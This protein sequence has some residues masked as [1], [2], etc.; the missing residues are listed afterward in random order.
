MCYIRH[1]V[2]NKQIGDQSEKAQSHFRLRGADRR[3]LE[4]RWHGHPGRETVPDQRPCGILDHHVPGV[5]V[6]P[7]GLR[8][9]R[10]Q[11]PGQVASI[12]HVPFDGP[13]HLHHRHD[14]LV[15]GEQR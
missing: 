15:L 10:G 7:G 13:H 11:A 5:P 14:L 4:R 12:R 2:R 9:E 3:V 8:R 6:H 1:L